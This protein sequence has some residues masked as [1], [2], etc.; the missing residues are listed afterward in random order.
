MVKKKFDLT[1][2]ETRNLFST[3]PEVKISEILAT[4]LAENVPLALAI[5]TEKARSE[6]IIAPILVELRK[7]VHHQISLFSGVDFTVNEE[8]GL[9]GICDFI[10]TRSPEMFTV[11]APVIMLVEAKN[12]NL[13]SGL[14]QCLAEMVAAQEFNGQ[15]GND[16][17][18]VYGV[19]TTGNLWKFI[20]LEDKLA[21]I[22]LPE[23]HINQ[24]GKI[25]GVLLQMVS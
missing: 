11:N 3:V 4:I 9:K 25:L 7:L 6:F 8:K 12:E 17:S 18:K 15:E 14:S 13:K 24:A 21:L 10:I 2:D 19:V 16:I 23:Y 22:D 1:L 5:S 20:I